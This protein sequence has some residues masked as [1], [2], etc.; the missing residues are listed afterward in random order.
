MAIIWAVSP[1]SKSGKEDLS[2]SFFFVDWEGDMGSIIRFAS[3][4]EILK[5]YVT[6]EGQDALHWAQ[7]ACAPWERASIRSAPTQNFPPTLDRPNEIRAAAT[8]SVHEAAR[9]L[10]T[11]V[12]EVYEKIDQGM[13][14]YQKEPDGTFRVRFE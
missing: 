7:Q 3:R 1:S 4:Y 6:C 13:L 9:R 14:R 11:T 12:A 2:A 10:G 8:V 5:I